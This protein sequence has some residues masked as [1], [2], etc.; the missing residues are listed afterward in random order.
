M[1]VQGRVCVDS[2]LRVAFLFVEENF[3]YLYGELYFVRGYL[4]FKKIDVLKGYFA[5]ERGVGQLAS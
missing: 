3:L 4:Y 5:C 1:R 2:L